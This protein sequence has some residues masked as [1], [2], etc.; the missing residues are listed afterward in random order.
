MGKE[1]EFCRIVDNARETGLDDSKE[2]MRIN[3]P[4]PE[5][6]KIY[7]DGDKSKITTISEFNATVYLNAFGEDL[8]DIK[9]GAEGLTLSLYLGHD[10]GCLYENVCETVDI[11]YCPMCGRKI[12]KKFS[13]TEMKKRY[14]HEHTYHSRTEDEKEYFEDILDI[15]DSIQDEEETDGTESK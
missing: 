12:S 3:I 4:L 8:E 1:C 5:P 14:R 13:L 15:L 10:D 7:A 2:I 9:D 6:T 11:N